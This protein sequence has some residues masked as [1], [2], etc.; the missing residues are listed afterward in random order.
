MQEV[1]LIVARGV[2][3]YLVLFLLARLLGK[4]QLTQLT[5]FDYVVGITLG[6]IA[7]SLTVDT[8]MK[9]IQPLTGLLTWVSLGFLAQWVTTK[10]RYAQKL[11]EG[12]PLIVI[13]NGQVMEESMGKSRYRMSDLLEQLRN[14]N[15]FD[16]S[17][18]EFAV[19]E[20]TGKLSVLKKSQYLPVTPKDLNL[21]TRYG[22]ISTELIYDGIVVDQNLEQFDLTRQWLEEKLDGLGI[23][24]VSEV[25]FASLDTQGNL[26]VDTYKDHVKVPV[27]ISDFPGPN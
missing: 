26:Y 25:F 3:A 23:Q 22:G 21:P 5:F 1:M 18:V 20:S 9:P 8:T 14:K 2:L 27:D 24:D 12:E 13:M 7:A 17:Q 16:I 4:E 15:I 6:S 19:W 11:L 10:S